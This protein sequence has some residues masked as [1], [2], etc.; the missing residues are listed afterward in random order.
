MLPLDIFPAL[1][2]L[3]IIIFTLGGL[4][5]VKRNVISSDGLIAG[6]FFGFIFAS[7][8]CWV[9]LP[10]PI[11][12]MLFLILSGTTTLSVL[13]AIMGPKPQLEGKYSGLITDVESTVYLVPAMQT[14]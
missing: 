13:G 3:F 11:E 2:F 9:A 5:I 10:L 4:Y 14:V 7:F 6:G 8:L 12:I 1:F